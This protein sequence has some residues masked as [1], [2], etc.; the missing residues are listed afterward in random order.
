M[1]EA[2]WS[3]R[4]DSGHPLQTSRQED[5]HIVRNAHAPPTT[6]SVIIQAQVAHSLGAV[7]SSRT[8]RRRLAERHFG[9]RRPLRVLH[10]TP[11]YRLLR[12][13]WLHAR[14]NWAAA[15]WNGL[16]GRL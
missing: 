5:H 12:L 2:G 14:G 11:T 6:S 3:A 4:P 1:I 8:I 9:S 7:V 15:E 13:E 10:L 16:S